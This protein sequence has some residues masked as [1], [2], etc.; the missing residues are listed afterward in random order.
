MKYWSCCSCSVAKSCLTLCNPVDCSTLGFPVLHYLP[1]FAQT[2][3]QWVGNAIQHLILCW[4]LLLLPSAIPSIRVSSNE[5]ILHIRWSKYWSF[6][7]STSPSDEYLGLI[8]FFR[9]DWFDLLAVQGTL[10]SLLQHHSSKAS[11]PQCL[12]FFMVQSYVCTWLLERP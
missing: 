12:T 3:V 4:L 5:L 9:I 7:F 8:F 10:K 1:E 6:G 11:I 2:Q